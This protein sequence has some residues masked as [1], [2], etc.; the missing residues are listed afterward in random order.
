MHGK[1]KKKIFIKVKLV[2][3]VIIFQ[4]LAAAAAVVM[5]VVEVGPR[6]TKPSLQVEKKLSSP[7]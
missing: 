4:N 2:K 7:Q 3:R 5:I 6:Y 1:E